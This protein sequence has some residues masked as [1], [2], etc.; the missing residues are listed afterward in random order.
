MKVINYSKIFKVTFS[1]KTAII[2]YNNNIIINGTY[3][4]IVFSRFLN[5][6]KYI[7]NLTEN[8]VSISKKNAIAYS[9]LLKLINLLK[10]IFFGVNFLFS[11]KISLVGIGFRIWIKNLKN[12]KV[13]LIKVGFSKDLYI[14][15][16]NNIIIYSLR[17]TLILIRGLQKFKVNQFCSFIRWF[18]KPDAFKGKGILFK[19]EIIFLK[20]GKQN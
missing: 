14:P 13:L 18:K 11:K 19:D 4:T 16:P 1:K 20:P 8:S 9:K 2:F 15:I 7:I 10:I 6:N 5:K 3:G 17:P 12:I